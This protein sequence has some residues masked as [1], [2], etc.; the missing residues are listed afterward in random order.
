MLANMPETA[1]LGR[2]GV[3]RR[4]RSSSARAYRVAARASF[5]LALNLA[6]TRVHRRQSWSLADKMDGVSESRGTCGGIVVT[7]VHVKSKTPLSLVG[8]G[9]QAKRV[10]GFE[11]TTFTLATCGRWV[12]N[13]DVL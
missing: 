7:R 1:I 5:Y 3:F 6:R 8:N 2:D 9:G 11:P 13:R 12:L 10:M 4:H